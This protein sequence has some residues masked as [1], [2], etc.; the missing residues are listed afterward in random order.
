MHQTM[1][2]GSRGSKPPREYDLTKPIKNQKFRM[3]YT[4]SFDGFTPCPFNNEVEVAK[5][6]P[7]DAVSCLFRKSGQN[8]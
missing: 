8:R 2:T 6:R 3:R 4:A 1:T 5:E 7:G